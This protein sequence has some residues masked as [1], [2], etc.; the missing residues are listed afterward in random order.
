[1]FLRLIKP[2]YAPSNARKANRLKSDPLHAHAVSIVSGSIRKR[3]GLNVPKS[4]KQK[5]KTITRKTTP[6]IFDEHIHRLKEVQ[7][8][9]AIAQSPIPIPVITLER[10]RKR[11]YESMLGG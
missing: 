2:E 7:R 3:I 4:L 10:L 11:D 6:C 8:G 9:W 5:L 1:M